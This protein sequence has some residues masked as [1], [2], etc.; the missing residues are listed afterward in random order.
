M[1]IGQTIDAMYIGFSSDVL[2]TEQDHR[3][4]DP[5]GAA[6]AAGG[7]GRAD[8]RDPRRE[9]V[10]AARLARPGEARRLRRSPPPTCSDALA[11]NDLPLRGG[12]APRARWCSVDL[13]ADHRPALGGGIPATW[14]S[15]SR[16]APSCGWRTWPTV[17][18][19]A[20]DYETAVG[21][22][23]QEAVYIGIQVAPDG[24][25]ARRDRRACAT[26]FPA[27]QAQLPDG[28]D[29]RIVYDSTKFVNSSISEV[30]KTLAEALL[31][32]TL[33][34]FAVPRLACARWSIPTI[35]MPLSLDR[36]LLRDARR[37]AITINLLTLLALVLAI[38]LV[39]DDAI[40]VVE[41]VNRHIEEG[42]TPA[43]GGDHGRARARRPD[44]RDDRGADRR[45]RADRLSRRPDRRAVHRVRVYAGRRGDRFRRWSR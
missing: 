8:R 44:H 15:S 27:I 32:V 6:Q 37:S 10:R 13:T 21:L 39:V 43:A 24:Q 40:I 20:E 23:R 16:T 42:M 41:N 4:P 3:L 1:T 26:A 30:V 14:W 31:I 18:L 11:A 7:R 36:H 19:G 28:L 22:R 9:A 2:P 38:G 12:H 25:P 29:G 35:A 17:T 34:V 5:R 33:V 45:V